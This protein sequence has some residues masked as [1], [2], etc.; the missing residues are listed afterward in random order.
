[1]TAKEATFGTGCH[2]ISAERDE[3]LCRWNAYNLSTSPT[4][5]VLDRTVFKNCDRFFYIWPEDAK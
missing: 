3:F 1:M 5:A 2:P 4:G